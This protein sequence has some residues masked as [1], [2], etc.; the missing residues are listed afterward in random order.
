M[1]SVEMK[2]RCLLYY[3][4]LGRLTNQRLHSTAIIY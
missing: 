1:R 4:A 3:A 2:N